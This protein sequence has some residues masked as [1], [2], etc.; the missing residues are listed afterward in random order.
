[1]SSLVM[2]EPLPQSLWERTDSQYD[3]IDSDDINRNRVLKKA[4]KSLGSA[5]STG[6][7]IAS[8]AGHT[9]GIVALATGAAISATGIGLAA[10]GVA[11]T[12]GS[13]VQAGRSWRKTSGHIS[14]L[15]EIEVHWEQFQCSFCLPGGRS[16]PGGNTT[17]HGY[18][19]RTVLPYIILQKDT[20]LTR[21]QISTFGGG[22]FVAAYEK[23]HGLKKA[24]GGTRGKLRSYYAHVLS[25]HLI[26]H[27]CEL[28]DAIVDEL[29][30]PAEREAIQRMNS[31]DAGDLLMD[32]MKSG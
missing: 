15:K 21:K 29:Y 6:G 1:V 7:T 9:G 2:D 32:K 14:G 23:L 20:K 8:Y 16:A 22:I 25:V 26:S 24:W 3:P 18:I 17:A 12:L 27:Y 11:L 10:G 28:A 30:T 5:G 19:A 13:M 31:D 4:A